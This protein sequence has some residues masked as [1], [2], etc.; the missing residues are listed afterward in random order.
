MSLPRLL[1][2][3][4][5]PL[6]DSLVLIWFFTEGSALPSLSRWDVTG[7]AVGHH[8]RR[9]GFTVAREGRA[10]A[11]LLFYGCAPSRPRCGR[12]FL[13]RPP[14]LSKNGGPSRSAPCG[15]DPPAALGCASRVEGGGRRLFRMLRSRGGKHGVDAWTELTACWSLPP[16]ARLVLCPQPT[17]TDGAVA[18]L[19]L[20]AAL[21][22]GRDDPLER[23]RDYGPLPKGR[24]RRPQ[25]PTRSRLP[26]GTS[27]SRRSR[28]R[29][30]PPSGCPNPKRNQ[31]REIAP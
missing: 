3:C 15:P 8:P 21:A 24:R 9:S 29:H 25:G 23:K 18:G 1:Q 4:I 27:V 19:A 28:E 12:G 22:E 17:A 26:R 16:R 20:G 10:A 31:K 14:C 2:H 13:I 5:R 7:R 30:E 11:R 6:A